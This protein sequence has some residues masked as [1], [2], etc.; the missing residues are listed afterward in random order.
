MDDSRSMRA[1]K[2]SLGRSLYERYKRSEDPHKKR[3]VKSA[4]ATRSKISPP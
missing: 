3:S 4:P 1:V 2:G